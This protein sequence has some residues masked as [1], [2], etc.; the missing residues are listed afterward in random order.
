MWLPINDE[1]FT[2]GLN[3]IKTTVP[4]NCKTW[5]NGIKANDSS[6]QIIDENGNSVNFLPWRSG[7]P[8]GRH[9]EMCVY[10]QGTPH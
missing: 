5:I 7:Q 9:V 4:I 6:D 10:I 1:D 2:K 3:A 8:N